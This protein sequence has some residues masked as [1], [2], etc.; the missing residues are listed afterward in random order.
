L[1][2]V[3]EEEKEEEEEEEEVLEAI[4]GEDGITE[5]GKGEAREY[6]ST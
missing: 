5:A 6:M 1:L 4:S 3:E 2:E